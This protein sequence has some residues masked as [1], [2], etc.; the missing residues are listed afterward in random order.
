M[1]KLKG[2]S[3]T[4]ITL[5][6]VAV[7]LLLWSFGT[8]FSMPSLSEIPPAWIKLVQDEGLLFELGVSMKLNAEAVAISAIISIGLAFLI[9]GSM[10]GRQTLFDKFV[11]VPVIALSKFRF[12]GM[13]GFVIIFTRIFGGGH[14]LK[15]ALLVFGMSVFFITSMVDVVS[16]TTKEE[17]DHTRSLKMSKWRGIFEVVVRGKLDQT[18]DMLRQNAAIGWMMLTMV[19]GLVRFEGGVGVIMLNESKYRNLAAVF[20][21]QL[22]VLF[23]GIVQDLFI[24]WLKDRFCPH[25]R[26]SLEKK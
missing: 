17:L 6:W 5:V 22:T 16:S 25:S 26:L 3:G 10:T 1:N 20:A 19:E 18:F 7:L 23:V 13:A 11:K 15:V 12:F 2:A 21:V 9:A 4:A 24:V 14:A 8:E